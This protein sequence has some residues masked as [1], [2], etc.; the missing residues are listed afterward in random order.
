[1]ADAAYHLILFDL[2]HTLLDFEASELHALTLCWNRF[3]K[4]AVAFSPFS[5]K[6]RQINLRIWHDVEAGK[7]KPIHVSV[8]RA[9]GVLKAFGFSGAEASGFGRLYAK[10]LSE[11]AV[12][13]PGAETGFRSISQRYK[14]GVITNGL[15]AVQHPRLDALR[16]KPL[17]STIQISEDTG[18]MKPRADIFRLALDEAGGCPERTLMVGDSVSSDFQGAINAGIDF[19]WVKPDSSELPLQFPKPKYHVNNI[20]DLN[21]LLA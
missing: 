18:T 13:L 15:T 8:E 1:M 4:Q 11:V 6:F 10:G 21:A 5:T 20:S 2:D 7:L 16:I 12:W 14:V 9:R 3:F 17:L 19:C